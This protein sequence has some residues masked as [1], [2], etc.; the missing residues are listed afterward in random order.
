MDFLFHMTD[1]ELFTVLVILG[2]AISIIGVL[3]V[4]VL[5]PHE[6]RFK[7]NAV[8]GT[9]SGLIGLIYGVLV[10]ISALYLINNLASAS[11][12]VQREANAV[13]NLYRTSTLLNEPV[14]TQLET[15]LINYLN[16]VITK[17][18]P[19]MRKNQNVGDT[20]DQL[21]D[22]MSVTLRGYP[23]VTPMD[24]IVIK[25]IM[26]EEKALYSAREERI[27]QSTEQLSAELWVVI[28][29]GT[30]LAIGINFLYGMNIWLHL[31]SASAAA[32]M[33]S[34]MIFLLLTLD[35]PFQGE[36]VIE[37][38]ALQ[39]VL[40]AAKRNYFVLPTTPA[41]VAPQKT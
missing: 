36:F 22:Q 41:I 23:L 21:V 10:G 20:G 1:A 3:V 13:A 2:I 16:L 33:A 32:L 26:E 5:V 8:I 11:D 12:A 25:D 39:T 37:P 28:L 40:D 30:I 7:D 24:S 35:R 29:I 6:V 34:S 14:R 17:E 31:L 27:A 9:V 4:K 15:Q 19:K 38:D 18:W